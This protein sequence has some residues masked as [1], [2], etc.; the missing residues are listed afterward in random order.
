[1]TLIFSFLNTLKLSRLPA[2]LQ[3]LACSYRC[4]D[5]ETEEINSGR[6]YMYGLVAQGQ[7]TYSQEN[8]YPAYC[9][10]FRYSRQTNK[11]SYRHTVS[12]IGKRADTQKDKQTDRQTVR[13]TV[14]KPF[15]K[16]DRPADR[17][18]DIQK[19]RQLE[20]R[21]DRQTDSIVRQVLV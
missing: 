14:S 4:I 11:P 19:V 15:R 2:T 13:Q 3:P 6:L 9:T 10:N 20:R 8:K 5:R 21:P 1:M 16:A 12:Q 7:D 17:K 18:T